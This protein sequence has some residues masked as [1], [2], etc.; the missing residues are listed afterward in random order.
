MSEGDRFERGEII[1]DCVPSV[2]K[3]ATK[4]FRYQSSLFTSGKGFMVPSFTIVS[5]MK[6]KVIYSVHKIDD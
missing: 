3:A 5:S 1:V 2:D 4:S 6:H